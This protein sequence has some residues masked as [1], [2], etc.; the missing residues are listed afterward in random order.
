MTTGMDDEARRS[1]WATKMDEAYQFM[2]Q[3]RQYPVHECGE[4]VV[5]LVDEVRSAGV[6]VIFSARPHVQ[7]LPRLY[8]LR[9]GL[10]DDFICCAR[11]RWES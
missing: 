8:L 1:F 7:G 9:T 10:I 3:I 4:P 2:G 11:A 6:E 5:S